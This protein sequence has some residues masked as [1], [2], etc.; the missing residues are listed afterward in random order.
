M[1]KD[2]RDRLRK[3]I[4]V[5]SGAAQAF[6]A[7]TMLSLHGGVPFSLPGKKKQKYNVTECAECMGKINP[8]RAGRLCKE[9]LVKRS[10]GKESNLT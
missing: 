4:Q 3:P 1:D 9:C 5:P 6:A 10:N 2:T 8:G 7:A